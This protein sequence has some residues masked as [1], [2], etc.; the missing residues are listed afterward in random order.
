MNTCGSPLFSAETAIKN[1]IIVV[2]VAA[3][4]V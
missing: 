2:A 4:A 1:I 3:A